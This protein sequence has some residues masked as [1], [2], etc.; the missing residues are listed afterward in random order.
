MRRPS[1][2]R[3]QATEG[4]RPVASVNKAGNVCE[5]FAGWED[6]FRLVG[7]TSSGPRF[8]WLLSWESARQRPRLALVTVVVG[9]GLGLGVLGYFRFD[10][11]G[12]AVVLALG[13]AFVGGYVASQ[14]L[15]AAS[16][17]RPAAQTRQRAYKAGLALATTFA[18]IAI[19]LVL[20]VLTHS[21]TVFFVAMAAGLVV[22]LALRLTVLR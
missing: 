20:G 14:E 18:A 2:E 15:Q 1:N 5:P 16:I 10:S 21:V 4:A 6:G 13:G 9:C 12:Y 11:V 22:G 8:G 19:A 7:V 17:P 3:P